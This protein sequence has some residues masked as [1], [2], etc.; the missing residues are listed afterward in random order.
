[1][2]IALFPSALGVRP[3]ITDAADRLR[4]AGHDPAIV[5]FYDGDSYD[6][7]DD[8][9]ARTEA[10]GFD[11][12]ISTAV[13]AVADEPDGLVVAGWS[14]GAACA[15]VVALQR[16]VAGAITFTNPIDLDFLGGGPWPSG[17]PLQIHYMPEDPFYDEG[18]VESVSQAV[19]EAGGKCEVYSYE[20]K[21]HLFT[22]PSL[23]DEFHAEATELV[24]E[25]TLAFLE[26]LSN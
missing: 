17:V 24:W 8:G 3:G 4:A 20:G 9:M 22:D 7:Y 10:I 25:R 26:S 16:P 23:P 18:S 15:Q 13:T 2:R 6:T 19:Q 21:A 12:L 14:N 11:Q 5:D 1:M